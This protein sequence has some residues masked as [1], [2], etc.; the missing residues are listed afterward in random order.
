[1]N[2][3]F[4]IIFLFIFFFFIHSIFAQNKE[5]LSQLI[6]AETTTEVKIVRDKAITALSK[7][8]T[9]ENVLKQKLAVIDV[10]EEELKA[11]KIEQMKI[12]ELRNQ[13]QKIAT[14]R[15]PAELIAI[16]ESQLI[17]ERISETKK[18]NLNRRIAILKLK[19][20]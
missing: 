11:I 9:A 4:Y 17:K 19:D 1:M 14:M 10:T 3:K 16:L 12:A 6:K 20:I 2:I 5:E 7:L 18:A 13:Y 8:E 15:T